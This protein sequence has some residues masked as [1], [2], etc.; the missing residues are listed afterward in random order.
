MV[1]QTGAPNDTTMLFLSDEAADKARN[2]DLKTL[3]ELDDRGLI[4][5]P[6]ESTEDFAKRIVTL[7]K[8]IIEL[9]DEL[10]SKDVV[11][12]NGVQ[13]RRDDR[14]PDEIFDEA[15]STTWDKFRFKID[16]VPGFFTFQKMGALFAG[17]AMYSYEDFFAVFLVRQSFQ[18]A[19]K[20]FL[21]TRDELMA[22]ELTHVA[23]VGYLTPNYEEYLAFQTS[24][25]RFRRIIGGVF[26]TPKDTYL[27]L[28]AM[29]A[30]LIAQ[31]VMTF[32]LG[33]RPIW[34][35][36]TPLF[37]LGAFSVIGWLFGCYFRN[38]GRFLKASENL[39]KT[40][41][42]APLPILFRAS[43]EEMRDIATL[44]GKDLRTWLKNRESES[45]RWQIIHKKLIKGK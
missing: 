21:Y 42:T 16:W 34:Q 20:W 6:N 7:R 23:H 12:F 44:T 31:F 32:T 5:G 8:N 40:F 18:K 43:E 15:A 10:I 24:E 3:I 11:D 13:L 38:R 17:C 4:I 1:E 36:P 25:S 14:I 30:L 19:R 33:P 39:K 2:G 27:V 26:R 45:I 28:G 9:N 22:H 41:K 37:F 35:L 29:F